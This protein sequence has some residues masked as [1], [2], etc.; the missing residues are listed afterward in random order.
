MSATASSTIIGFQDIAPGESGTSIG[1]YAVT[2]APS[3]SGIIEI[4]FRVNVFSG[5]N[6][7]WSDTF[8][9]RIYPTGVFSRNEQ[10]L[11]NKF[12]LEQ[13][14]PNPFNPA[15]TINFSLAQ[16]SHVKITVY[17]TLGQIVAVLLDGF[18]STGSHSVAWD[19]Q[20]LPGGIY[21]YKLKAGGFTA[22]KKMF[23]QK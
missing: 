22:S 8:L 21:I 23:L 4:P 20:N 3:C 9:V 2:V 11:P 5:G 19:A 12:S 14:C 7:F 15:T 17:N 6:M 10:E 18:Q 1:I 13:N 16:D